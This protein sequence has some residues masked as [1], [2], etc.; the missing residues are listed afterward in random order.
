MGHRM[1]GANIWCQHWM[2]P[3]AK[4]PQTEADR[5]ATEECLYS[6]DAH[7]FNP[8]PGLRG[9]LQQ[10]APSPLKVMLRGVIFG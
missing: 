1:L 3:Q 7:D 10:E 5:I 6:F 8:I 4:A 9:T 2:A